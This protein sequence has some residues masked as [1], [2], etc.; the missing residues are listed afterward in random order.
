GAF[1]LQ[2][3]D[4]LAAKLCEIRMGGEEPGDLQ[5]REARRDVLIRCIYGVD[6]NP[7]AVELCKFTLWLHCAHPELPLSYLDHHVRLGDSLI[8]GFPQAVGRGERRRD[9]PA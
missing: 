4:A 3:L 6:R 9:L 5:L 8:G 2:A 7:L 1:L